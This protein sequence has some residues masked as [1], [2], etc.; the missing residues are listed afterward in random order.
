MTRVIA[1]CLLRPSSGPELIIRPSPWSAL[2]VATGSS[3]GVSPVSTTTR[4][5]KPNLIAKSRSR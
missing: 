3:A 2:P 1:F 5:S 4:T